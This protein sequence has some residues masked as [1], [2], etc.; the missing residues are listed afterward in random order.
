M[1]LEVNGDGIL[2]LMEKK[3]KITI[4]STIK[5]VSVHSKVSERISLKKQKISIV[6][7]TDT[8]FVVYKNVFLEFK[9]S[10]S[11]QSNKSGFGWNT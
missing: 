4:M 1:N 9:K 3:V 11:S 6:S 7:E 10:N 8:G 5:T 2:F